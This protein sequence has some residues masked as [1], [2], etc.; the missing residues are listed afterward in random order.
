MKTREQIIEYL[1]GQE[2]F[3]GL[4]L[5][6]DEDECFATLLTKMIL[7]YPKCLDYDWARINDDFKKWLDDESE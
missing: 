6:I 7:T 4:G 3:K 5:N 1:N 2:W